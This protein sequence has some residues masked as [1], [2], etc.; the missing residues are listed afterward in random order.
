MQNMKPLFLFVILFLFQNKIQAQVAFSKK[1]TFPTSIES[2]PSRCGIYN[3]NDGGFWLMASAIEGQNLKTGGQIAHFAADGTVIE[4]KQVLPSAL[5][6][7]I[8]ISFLEMP[9]GNR[10][11]ILAEDTNPAP[12][13]NFLGT[14]FLQI[15]DTQWNQISSTVLYDKV[16][17]TFI[18][19]YLMRADANNNLYLHYY[20]GGFPKLC[21]FDSKANLL[22]SKYIGI[23]T[24]SGACS[25]IITKPQ[26]KGVIAIFYNTTL[27]ETDIL[28]ID[29]NGIDAGSKKIK[30]LAALDIDFLKNG[31]LILT[32]LTSFDVTGGG[33]INQHSWVELSPDFKIVNT[34]YFSLT[35]F[36]GIQ[37]VTKNDGSFVCYS[38]YFNTNIFYFQFNDQRKLVNDKSYIDK[39]PLTNYTLGSNLIVLPNGNTVS[40]YKLNGKNEVRLRQT[41][42]NLELPSCQGK[43]SCT[44]V[45][46]FNATIADNTF[47]TF[48]AKLPVNT[49]IKTTWKDNTLQIK[50]DCN[51]S[52][53]KRE[54][55][56]KDTICIGASIEPKLIAKQTTNI[57]W[58]FE[59]GSPNTSNLLNPG[60]I[61]FDSPG[62]FK[63]QAILK[64]SDCES[65]TLTKFVTVFQPPNNTL[66]KDTTL[67]NKSTFLVKA[68][69]QNLTNWK[70][71][72]SQTNENPRLLTADGKYTINATLGECKINASILVKFRKADTL[73]SAPD[74][75]C[76]KTS[77][78]LI[79]AQKDDAKHNWTISNSTF[80]PSAEA[81]PIPF[82]LPKG[83]YN[84]THSINN[85]GCKAQFVKKIIVIEAP[86]VDLGA[87]LELELGKPIT[88]NPKITPLNVKLTW[89]NGS[90]VA[91]RLINEKGIYSIT[92]NSF[93]C[94][95]SDEIIISGKPAIFAPNVFAPEGTNKVFEVFG[96]DALE[97]LTLEIFDRLG[98]FIIKSTDMKWDATFRGQLVQSGV[99]VYVARFRKKVD[100]SEIVVKGD[101]LVLY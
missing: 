18:S 74:S 96:N 54:I 53:E 7:V 3:A 62:K 37:T 64:I 38:S 17:L 55:V 14:V 67:C 92:I 47:A 81:N 26:N 65:D 99:F 61:T 79:S 50:D 8:I 29:E 4:S 94:S 97:P 45:G 89:D 44:E 71:E 84:I 70:W 12:N 21:K 52:I 46:P 35:G 68:N 30:N 33:K 39:L 60:M 57:K 56:A 34:R 86:K 13:N 41:G 83:S 82:L 75:L 100:N 80:L 25:N 16:T 63:I 88:L 2:E 20:E 19:D 9:N 93:A 90:N 11:F 95:A 59:N 85:D 1:V 27:S 66:P 36:F 101:V 87:D 76:E 43:K 78:S 32:G 10:A 15:F 98:N 40:A 73:F 77:I 5:G 72:D 51:E 58:S 48:P 49:Q 91:K 22:W 28:N 31:N 6:E 24:N 42:A 23:G 69:V